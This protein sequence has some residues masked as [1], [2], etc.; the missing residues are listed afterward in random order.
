MLPRF[1]GLILESW[2]LCHECFAIFWQKNE[3]RSTPQWPKDPYFWV[4]I[5]KHTQK[6][7]FDSTYSTFCGQ[8]CPFM[9]YEL[10]C[11]ICT[12]G[13]HI[14]VI[15]RCLKHVPGLNELPIHY[16]FWIFHYGFVPSSTVLLE[17]R[18]RQQDRQSGTIWTREHRTWLHP[19]K[20]S[21][22]SPAGWKTN[23]N[24]ER[25]IEK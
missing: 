17:K 7:G 14:F 2:M 15:E 9:K 5:F 18:A 19:W 20:K 3:Q 12:L 25:T 8:T 6:F 13:V 4:Y 10:D 1:A 16:V 21:V 24:T 11:Q 22:D 23:G